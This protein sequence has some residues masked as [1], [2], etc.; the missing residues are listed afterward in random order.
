MLKNVLVGFAVSFIGSVPLGYLN[1]VGYHLYTN[2][3]N[4]ALSLYLMGVI[5]VEAIVIYLTL[6]FAQKL[7]SNNKLIRLIE[8]ASIFFML[9]LAILFFLNARSDTNADS[10]LPNYPDYAPFFIGLALNCV[11]I[12]QLPFWIGWN[13]YLINN[14]FISTRKYLRYF[15]LIGTL[16]GP[17]AGMYGFILFLSYVAGQSDWLGDYVFLYFIPLVFIG[18]AVLQTIKYYRKYHRQQVL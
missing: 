7:A 17:F 10:T 13:L 3:G 4:E 12:M 11:N 18:M 9:L 8:I 15:Y 14:K 1:I 2:S 6:I 16:A 5:S